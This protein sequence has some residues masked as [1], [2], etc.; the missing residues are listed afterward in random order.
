M[1]DVRGIAHGDEQRSVLEEAHRHGPVAPRE[2]G[3][4][5]R[6]RLVVDRRHAEV[7]EFERVLLGEGPSHRGPRDELAL[8][9]KLAEAE[10]R[11]LLLRDGLVELLRAEGSAPHEQRAEGRP[12]PVMGRF[13]ALAFIGRP[14]P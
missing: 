3:R 14:A 10:A 1:D 9:E 11:L 6:H 5:Q 12:E 2:R 4:Q 8:D 7:D 13:H